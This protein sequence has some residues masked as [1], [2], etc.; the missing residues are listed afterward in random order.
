MKV[1]FFFFVQTENQESGRGLV[2][3]LRKFRNYKQGLKDFESHTSCEE[4]YIGMNTHIR[5]SEMKTDELSSVLASSHE[6]TRVA[7]AKN[8]TLS[9]FK[10]GEASGDLWVERKTSTLGFRPRAGT[11][12]THYWITAQ[13]LKWT[14]KNKM[15]TFFIIF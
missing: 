5:D 7:L 3:I 2:F 1:F 10:A 8:R 6:E 14:L 11:K 13:S 12:G 15:H 4:R 9:H